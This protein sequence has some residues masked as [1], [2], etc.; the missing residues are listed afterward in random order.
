MHCTNSFFQDIW[1]IH[2]VNYPT[3]LSILQ[4]TTSSGNGYTNIIRAR[5]PEGWFVHTHTASCKAKGDEVRGVA[6]L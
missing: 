6:V 2:S 3:V 1:A 4:L 5:N